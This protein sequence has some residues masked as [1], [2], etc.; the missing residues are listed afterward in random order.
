MLGASG[1][2]KTTLLSCILGLDKLDSGNI[3]FSKDAKS[4]LRIGFMPQQSSLAKDLTLIEHCNLF[5][6]I[7]GMNRDKIKQRTNFLIELMEISNANERTENLSGGELQRVSLII[8]L[9]HD[10]ELLFLD[11]PTVGLDPLLR[12]K[13]WTYLVNSAL[14]HKITVVI[15]T[16]YIEHANQATCVSNEKL[17]AAKP[18]LLFIIVRWHF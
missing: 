4:K 15:T 14:A 16:H 8:T 13:V 18:L 17:N 1:C 5:G 10:P 3:E 6:R 2:G 12:L 11:E 7:Y 9:L